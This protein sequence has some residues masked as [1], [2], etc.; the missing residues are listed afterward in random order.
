MPNVKDN[1]DAKRA[2]RDKAIANAIT[3]ATQWSELAR[4]LGVENHKALRDRARQHYGVFKSKGV[5]VFDARVRAFVAAE[6]VTPSR[7]ADIRTSFKR[8]DTL[9]LKGDGTLNDDGTPKA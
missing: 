7:V 3:N 6:Y 1:A 2:E 8:G 9:P 4:A 5:G